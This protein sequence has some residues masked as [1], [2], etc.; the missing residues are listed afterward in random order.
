M[1]PESG[2]HRK[3]L[4]TSFNLEVLR[5]ASRVLYRPL[6]IQ[7]ILFFFWVTEDQGDQDKRAGPVRSGT[8]NV[9]FQRV[10]FEC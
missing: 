6:N 10:V 3:E 5:E 9:P 7:F 1:P 8:L 4:Q 2:P